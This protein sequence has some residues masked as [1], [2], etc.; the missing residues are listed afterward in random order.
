MKQTLVLLVTVTLMV[1]S[2]TACG[3]TTN[4]ADESAFEIANLKAIEDEDSLV[5]SIDTKIVYYLFSTDETDGYSGYGYFAPYI[6]ENG[7]FC[8]YVNDEIVEIIP[9]TNTN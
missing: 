7:Y 6:S 1:C 9:N 5:Y 2:L 4:K 8:K 3:T